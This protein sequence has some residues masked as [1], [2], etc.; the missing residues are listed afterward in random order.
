MSKQ[1]C[2]AQSRTDPERAQRGS[3]VGRR[4]RPGG[5]NQVGGQSSSENF[6]S[7]WKSI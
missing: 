5:I 2:P 7:G 6:G 4:R 1:I 3:A